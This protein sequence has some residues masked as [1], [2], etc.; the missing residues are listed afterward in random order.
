MRKRGL[1]VLDFAVTKRLQCSQ[2]PKKKENL[3][4]SLMRVGESVR[5]VDRCSGMRGEGPAGVKIG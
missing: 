2:R 1:A 3:E 5:P 4:G